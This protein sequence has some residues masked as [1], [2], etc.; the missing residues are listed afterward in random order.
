MAG[1]RTIMARAFVQAL[2]AAGVIRDAAEIRRLVIDARH[3]QPLIM[4]LECFADERILDVA[5]TLDGIEIR[6]GTPA[7]PVIRERSLPGK[8][9]KIA[10][11][12]EG[13]DTADCLDPAV[14]GAIISLRTIADEASG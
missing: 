4:Y 2:Q 10:D 6:T 3:D 7:E 8:L 12:L 11:Q 13:S 1:P 5:T 14:Y 9:R